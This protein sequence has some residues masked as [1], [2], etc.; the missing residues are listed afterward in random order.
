MYFSSTEG[1]GGGLESRCIL[2]TLGQ[3]GKGEGAEKIKPRTSGP[4][5]PDSKISF[6][7]IIIIRI[8]FQGDSIKGNWI[9]MV[10]N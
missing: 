9:C 1:G 5:L 8:S 7:T 2:V 4:T 10:E 3:I 6:H